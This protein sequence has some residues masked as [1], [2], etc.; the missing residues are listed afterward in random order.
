M[1]D[2]QTTEE[3]GFKIH[4]L[5]QRPHDQTTLTEKINKA[6]QTH[7]LKTCEELRR[8]GLEMAD[9]LGNRHYQ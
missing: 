1:N 7:E 6:I 9:L 5:P 2:K 4:K 8:H 3:T